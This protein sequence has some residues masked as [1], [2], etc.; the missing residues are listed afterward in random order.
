[1]LKRERGRAPTFE[2]LYKHSIPV[3]QACEQLWDSRVMKFCWRPEAG[4]TSSLLYIPCRAWRNVLGLQWGRIWLEVPRRD[5]T[6]KEHKDTWLSCIH[7]LGLP[8][9]DCYPTIST[10]SSLEM[11]TWNDS[12]LP[13]M[14]YESNI[15]LPLDSI[16]HS[17]FASLLM[18]SL[19]FMLTSQ[20]TH[21]RVAR[22]KNH[23]D[24][25]DDIVQ[26]SH[27]GAGIKFF[28]SLLN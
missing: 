25:K 16:I 24:T 3:W 1:M 5:S 20:S 22:K 21:V 15:E 8:V 18:R 2:L 17:K 28:T 4:S 23:A 14:V 13:V 11:L 27:L 19:N 7:H 10:F 26:Y 12:C 6:I 9:G